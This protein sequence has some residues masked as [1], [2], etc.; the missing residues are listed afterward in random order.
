MNRAKT[1]FRKSQG[2]RRR[3]IGM[4]NM[5]GVVDLFSVDDGI[6]ALF[7]KQQFPR[8]SA[9]AEPTPI[10]GGCYGKATF[11]TNGDGLRF[12][13]IAAASFTTFHYLIL[14]VVVCFKPACV[15]G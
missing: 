7:N 5:V 14:S 4:R 1:A 10:A 15:Q 8:D 6:T 11:F 13:V 3:I 12:A 9:T 2:Q